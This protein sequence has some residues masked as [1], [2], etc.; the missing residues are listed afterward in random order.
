MAT[1]TYQGLPPAVCVPTYRVEYYI[2]Y[3]MV[4]TLLA[5]KLMI[6]EVAVSEEQ[7]S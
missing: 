2:C 1:I 5:S 4:G 7:R 3:R 6:Y